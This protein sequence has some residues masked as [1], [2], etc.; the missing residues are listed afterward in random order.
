MVGVG[1]IMMITVRERTKEIG[2]RKALGATPRAIIGMIVQEALVLT[3]IAG[4]AGLV[5]GVGAVEGIASLLE[6][7][8]LESEFFANPEIDLA[9]A[10]Y[11]LLVLGI[12]GLAA[13]LIPGVR[14]ARIHPVLALREGN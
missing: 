13:G 6:Q 4:Y 14:A 10:L 3:S 12:A 9:A 8:N 11:A 1:N 7:F 5:L 2:I